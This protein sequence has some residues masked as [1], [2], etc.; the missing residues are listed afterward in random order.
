MTDPNSKQEIIA[1]LTQLRDEGLKFWT[2]IAA[3]KFAVKLGD[4]WSP[5]DNVRHLNKST[6]PVAK[7]MRVPKLALTLLVGKA[8]RPSRTYSE[9]VSTYQQT[10]SGGVDAGRFAPS[11]IPQPADANAWQV[12]IVGELRSSLSSLI[13]ITERWDEA[14]LDRYVLPHPLIGKLTV[15][16]MLF[17]TLYH[18]TH[19]RNN[20]ERRMPVSD[21]AADAKGAAATQ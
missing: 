8:E 21:R 2:S 18:H 11:D 15:R 14:N 4:A 10:V 9:L 1:A 5:S 6:E 20:V 16:E 13:R 19:H 17:F 12:Q 3:E 7:A